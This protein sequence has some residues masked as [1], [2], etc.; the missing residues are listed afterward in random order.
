MEKILNKYQKNRWIRLVVMRSNG[1]T[2]HF[3]II[4]NTMELYIIQCPLMMLAIVNIHLGQSFF[5]LFNKKIL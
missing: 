4:L 1:K 2:L 5:K 3:V